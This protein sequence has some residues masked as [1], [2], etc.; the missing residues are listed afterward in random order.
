MLDMFNPAPV[1][2]AIVPC[3][4]SSKTIPQIVLDL[5]TKLGDHNFIGNHAITIKKTYVKPLPKVDPLQKFENA[6]VTFAKNMGKFACDKKSQ[7]FI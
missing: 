2:K 5:E 7:R 3:R 6:Y 1:P 4:T